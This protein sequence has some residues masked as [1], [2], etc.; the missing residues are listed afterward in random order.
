MNGSAL[1]ALGLVFTTASQLRV[2][3]VPLGLGELCL[4]LW[5][6][7]ALLHVLTSD[8]VSN[9][10]ALLLLGTFWICFAFSLSVGTC[11]AILLQKLD[12]GSMLHDVFAYLVVA[13]LSCL[14][15]ATMKADGG[16]AP[17]AMVADYILEHLLGH[18][19]CP[20]L[21]VHP[22]AIG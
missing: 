4:G 11:Q 16:P 20:R 8:S 18:A 7:L 6:G 17:I 12:P 19:N 10:R 9:P 22:P 1:L 13:A 15:A 14:V 21:G 5:L 2:P 3:G